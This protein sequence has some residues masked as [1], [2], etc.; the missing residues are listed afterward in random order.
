LISQEFRGEELIVLFPRIAALLE[1]R[2]RHA[3]PSVKMT[4]SVPIKGLGSDK[5]HQEAHAF[6]DDQSLETSSQSLSSQ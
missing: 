6:V 3:I 2:L 4:V 5:I 1:H